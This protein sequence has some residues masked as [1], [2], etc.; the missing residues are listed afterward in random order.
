ME[1][2]PVL[3]F[4]LAP[5]GVTELQVLVWLSPTARLFEGE[6]LS[7]DFGPAPTAVGRRLSVEYTVT[8]QPYQQATGLLP[9]GAQE[10]MVAV[11]AV[12]NDDVE[13]VLSTLLA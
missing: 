11:A 5:A 3:E 7:M 1:L 2:T 8:P 12:A 9:Q 10:V 13:H 4:H 6:A